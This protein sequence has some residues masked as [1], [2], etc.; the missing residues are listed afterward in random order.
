MFRLSFACCL[1]ALCA[2]TSC[3]YGQQSY[4][5][6]LLWRI[7][8]KGLQH[9][10][11]LYGTMHLTDNRLF[12]FGDSVYQA[13]ERSAGLAIEV[14]PDEMGAYYVNKMFDEVE[15]DKLQEILN[16]KDFKKYSHALA[17]K[18]KKPASEITTND[19]VT[20][21]N[22]WLNDY[23]E[24]GEMATFVDAYLYDIARRQGKW[25]G[26]VEDITDQ[27]GLLDDLVDKSDID[28]LLAGDSSYIKTASNRMMENM[29]ELYTNQDLPGIE[30]LMSAE[31][32]EYKDALLIKRNVKMARRIDS[33]TALRTMFIAIG[34][35][36]LPG[37]SG[38]IHL[39]KQK[40]FTVE[41]VF[42]T[43]KIN[44]KNYTF[45]EV[46]LPWKE[47]AD[48]QG[49]YKV[50]MPGE[51]VN[52]K[53]YG[54]IEM[55]Y[56]FDVYNLS[57]YC[58][59]AVINP[60]STANKDSML[61][62]MAQRMFRTE[63]KLTA[64]KVINNG[65]EGNE[66]QQV[67]KGENVR[68]QAYM[69]ENVVYVAFIYAIKETTLTSEDANNFFSSLNITKTLPQAA[70]SHPFT[71]SVM[72]I[73]FIAPTEI[74][75]NKKLSSGKEDSWHVSGFTGTDITN[76]M[77]II[78]FSKDV[79]PAHY[80]SSDTLLQNKLVE[81]LKQQYTD[82]HI[83]SI[84]VQGNKGI[85]IRGNHTDQPGLFMEAVS[86]IK[87]N[88]NIVLLVITDSLHLQAAE[89]KT[90]FSSLRFIAPAAIPWAVHTT[91]DSL[92]SA[93]IPG[94]FRTLDNGESRFTYAFDTTSASSY[95]IIP[96]TLSKY[97]WFK[98]DSLFWKDITERYTGDDSLI[99]AT[100]IL[101]ND[102]PAK[103]LL[104]KEN[105]SYKRMR[106]VLHD[107]KVY[108]VMV[109]GD[110]DFVYHPDATAFLNSFRIHTPQQ[111]RNFTT[112][113]KAPLLVQD[114]ASKDS[115]V[116]R[117]AYK[118][119]IHVEF[120]RNDVPLLQQAL[121]KQ[122]LSPY[123]RE[124]S[125]HIN[126]RFAAE[127]GRLKDTT[128]IAFIKEQYPLLTKE[129]EYLK[130]PALATLADL[131]TAASYTALTQLL[132][133]YSPPPTALDYQMLRAFKDSME[134]TTSIFPTLQKLAK[135]SVH[136]P[137][138]ANLALALQ[139]SGFI[140]QEQLAVAQNDYI[141]S[142]QQLL[143]D[144]KRGIKGYYI[145]DDLLKLTGSFNT[146]AANEVLKSYL[147][148][149]D[150]Y[151]K[152]EAALQL[153]KNKQPVPATVLL[154]LAADP[155]IRPTLYQALKELK[156]T[157]LFPKQYATQQYFAEAAIHI[158]ASDDYTVLKMIFLAKKTATY[159]GKPYTFYLYRVVLED[160]DPAGYLGIAGGYTP[161]SASLTATE[162][163]S[164][165]YW[166]EIYTAGKVNI[167][168]KNF[169]T[170]KAKETQRD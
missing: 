58:T 85:R 36:H 161:G 20:E 18:F 139:D 44:A 27:A 6:S 43:K 86:L 38:V 148:A 80:L 55:K 60:R 29:V 123:D 137:I 32:P 99:Q 26:G 4:P 105:I 47:T 167:F 31:S 107:D 42:S 141:L 15:G 30:A 119:L 16:E 83:D 117:E 50:S 88:R 116:R 66:Y 96:D 111:N 157:A 138:L 108:Q 70:G 77:Y 59:M 56:L 165:I 136:G 13:I 73:S 151:V 65:V 162:D 71:D 54:L 135:S 24:K 78:L 166:Q 159:K 103:E 7:S 21:K 9:P 170:S 113:S 1:V 153:I 63:K 122:Y 8:G 158:A 98:N 101:N 67:N 146:T 19:I 114:L 74:T 115:A 22:K 142:A 91:A 104:V 10:S 149:A 17:R 57:N 68:L 168:F 81:S 33:L 79:K 118:R 150:L 12:N 82:L 53:L 40:G 164:D 48:K 95:Y 75:Y 131:H 109:S 160:D 23:F 121:L 2:V 69:Y 5:K 147:T 132:E 51:P 39:L 112:Q 46:R 92:F 84:N 62:E 127:L 76:G 129:K 125:D 25:V 87:N 3:T 140:K 64:K 156:H 124:T 120:S 106:L 133:Q 94:T 90:M 72:G 11:Y 102:Q 41:P 34:A 100:D 89:T 145:I 52:L 35:A 49:L 163:I 93:R 14:N 143:P 45:K 152:K 126:L 128:T 28:F 61:Q 37:D 130:K 155:E 169:L 154:K 144:V 110:K 97:T 134:L